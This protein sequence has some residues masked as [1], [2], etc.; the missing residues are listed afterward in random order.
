MNKHFFQ[1]VLLA[2]VALAVSL[3]ATAVDRK[4]KPRHGKPP[5]VAAHQDGKAEARLIEIYR[6]IGQARTREALALSGTLVRDHPNFQLAQLVHGDLLSSLTRPVR[7]MGD[8]PETTA[9]AN[10]PLLADLR[11]ES[12]LRLKALRERPPAGTVPAP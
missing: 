1:S 3:P 7:A 9:R 6:L 11:E 5:V 4:K 2:F 8:V 10:A 12:L